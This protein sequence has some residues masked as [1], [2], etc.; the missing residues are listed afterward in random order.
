MNLDWQEL[1]VTKVLK[2]RVVIW[3]QG[4]FPDLQ[5]LLDKEAQEVF[6]ALL[7]LKDQ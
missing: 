4:V 6:E 3:A 7:A 2:V 1:K 5:E